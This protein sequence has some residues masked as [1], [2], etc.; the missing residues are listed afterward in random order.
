[1]IKH[2]EEIYGR[3]C[4]TCHGSD[5]LSRGMFPDLRYSGALAGA[6]P[7]RAIVI[8]GA[9]SQK[10]M[11]SF[12]AAGLTNDDAEAVRAFVVGKAIAAKAALPPPAPA[13]AAAPHAN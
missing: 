9:L 11:V 12:K 4:S 13:P 6:E 3:F 10:G 8:D 5:G 1:M 2:G 7:F